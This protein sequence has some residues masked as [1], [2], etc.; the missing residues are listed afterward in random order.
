M[1]A[2]A[3]L[4]QYL[5]VFE[6]GD[7]VLDAGPDPA[8]CAVMVIADDAAGL[9]A[10]GRGDCGDAAVA[11]VA[12]DVMVAGEQ[13]RD[14][15]AGDDD[16]VA[17]TG[18]ALAGDDHAA[19][20]GADDDL[21]VDAAAV[22]LADSGDGLVVHRDQGGVDDP[23]VGAAV[24]PAAPARPNK[25]APR[26]SRRRSWPPNGNTVTVEDCRISTWARLWGKRIA[27][28]SLAPACC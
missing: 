11:A 27:L 26:R 21:G 28:F 5:P 13:M 17:V 2:A 25:P 1:A 15:C 20:V 6:P 23:W 16:V 22:V 18:P 3:A 14:G 4:P 12:G 7:D 8:V 24:N 19:P 10:P 9:V